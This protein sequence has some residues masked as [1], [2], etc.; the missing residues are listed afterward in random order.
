M[1]NECEQSKDLLTWIKDYDINS[2]SKNKIESNEDKKA[3]LDHVYKNSK[4]IRKFFFNNYLTG[5]SNNLNVRSDKNSYQYM[6]FFGSNKNKNKTTISIDFI[7]G[8]KSKENNDDNSYSNNKLF[9]NK[10][11]E[12][13]KDNKTVNLEDENDLRKSNIKNFEKNKNSN[14]NLMNNYIEKN[15]DQNSKIGNWKI[16][17]KI[18]TQNIS[19]DIKINYNIMNKSNVDDN[20][21]KKRKKI[22]YGL[23]YKFIKINELNK[24]DDTENTKIMN[25]NKDK[26][27]KIVMKEKSSKKQ[28]KSYY[29]KFYN[30][31]DNKDIDNRDIEKYESKI[32][33]LLKKHK[34]HRA[35]YKISQA[36]S[37]DN[38]VKNINKKSNNKLIK[39]IKA[40]QINKKNDYYNDDKSKKEIEYKFI[41]KIGEKIQKNNNDK[42]I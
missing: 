29:F 28:N 23:R 4:N 24:E 19:Q 31:N 37:R 11:Y 13:C 1:F 27:K 25:I 35:T 16:S 6:N 32:K 10:T 20:K 15:N 42:K 39:K 9:I 40:P 5:I 36:K 30:G 22:K 17:Q 2:I 8:D 41:Q 12:E 21:F 3:I 7:N 34:S 18:N 38:I 26:E 33:M 14:I